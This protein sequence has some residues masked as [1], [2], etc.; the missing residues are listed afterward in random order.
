M[1]DIQKDINNVVGKA[2]NKYG[3]MEK[4]IFEMNGHIAD[5]KAQVKGKQTLLDLL[6]SAIDKAKNSLESVKI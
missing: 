1:Y 5:L 6:Y 3:S 2:V 4:A